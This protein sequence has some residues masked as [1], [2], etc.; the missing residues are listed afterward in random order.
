MLSA[1]EVR[2]H[3]LLPALLVG[4][5]LAPLPLADTV[6]REERLQWAPSPSPP[7]RFVVPAPPPPVYNE[8]SQGESP[9]VRP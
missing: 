3:R 2:M 7:L 1:V 8:P 5:I 9:S 4:L 6:T